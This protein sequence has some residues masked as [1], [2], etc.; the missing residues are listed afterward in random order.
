M[1]GGGG[2][3]KLANWDLLKLRVGGWGGLAIVPDLSVFFFLCFRAWNKLM[4]G[5][6]TTFN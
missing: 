1:W 6:C 3:G 5:V 4:T 2:E